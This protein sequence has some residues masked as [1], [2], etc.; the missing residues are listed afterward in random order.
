MLWLRLGV[1]VAMF[2]FALAAWL[3]RGRRPSLDG[4]L[5]FMLPTIALVGLFVLAGLSSPHAHRASHGGVALADA[6]CL[7]AASMSWTGMHRAGRLRS[8][9]RIPL[10]VYGLG[11]GIF[12]MGEAI[13]VTALNW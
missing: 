13:A 12:F 2:A 1:D 4:V 7:A 3:R 11:I 9:Y 5:A 6:G 8:R 10:V